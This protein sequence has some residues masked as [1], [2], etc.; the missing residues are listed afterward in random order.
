M[1]SINLVKELNSFN[2]NNTNHVTNITKAYNFTKETKPVTSTTKTDMFTKEAKAVSNS[3]KIYTKQKE[4][5]SITSSTKIDKNSKETKSITSSTEIDKISKETKS[6][7]SSNN[8]DINQ[9]NLTNETKK[10]SV[11]NTIELT[12]VKVIP[13]KKNDDLS[14][15]LSTSTTILICSVVT[16]LVAFV[17]GGL[18]VLYRVSFLLNL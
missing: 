3:S 9:N 17:V 6:V 12:T 16:I 2:Q 7:A 11:T 5:K 13:G 18:V 15:G 14:L 4:T 10:S 8:V 1:L